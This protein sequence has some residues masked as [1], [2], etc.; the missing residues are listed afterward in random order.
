[1]GESIRLLIPTGLRTRPSAWLCI[2]GSLALTFGSLSALADEPRSTPRDWGAHV[3]GVQHCLGALEHARNEIAPVTDCVVDHLF[4]RSADGALRIVEEYGKTRFGE[5]FHIDRRLGFTASTGTFT[6]DLDVVIPLSA[7]TALEDASV[8]RSLFIQ[9]G[10]T[11]WQDEQGFQR[12]DA[13][14][15]FV[16]RSL[17]GETLDGGILG[18]SM[19]MQENLERG[20]ARMVSGLEY[21][22]GWGQG[23]LNHYLPL[24]GWRPGRSGYEERALGGVELGYETELSTTID[25][26]VAAGRWQNKDGSD[27]WNNRVRL[28]ISWQPHPWLELRGGWDDIGTAENS[29]AVHVSFTMPLGGSDR[30]RARW[31]GLGRG[32]PNSRINDPKAMWNSVTHLDR[33]EFAEREM[34][35]PGTGHDPGT[36]IG[37]ISKQRSPDAPSNS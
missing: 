10:I 9:Q 30:G 16:H 1:M 24:T 23:S 5:Y 7:S 4:S 12:S 18:T 11:R 29:Q 3:F 17:L 34:P 13:R 28:G 37:E 15:G 19:F 31:Q 6:A 21:L 22:G 33:I 27:S 8:T 26:N 14:M 36:L 20:H 32:D 2:A 35:S 25:L